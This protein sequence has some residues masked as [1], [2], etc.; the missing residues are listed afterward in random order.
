[1]YIGFGSVHL[2]NPEMFTE[3]VVKAAKNTDTRILI[4]K[5]WTGLGNGY[6]NQHIYTIGD[7]PH[8]TLFP[9]MAGIIHHGGSGTTHT[10]ARSGIPQFI[11]PQI[12]DQYYWGYS[13]YKQGIGPK[14]V[15]PK[16]ITVEKLS[17]AMEMLKNG[18][19]R[20][21]AQL[22]AQSMQH[23][24]GVAGIVNIVTK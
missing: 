3:M 8:G 10:A 17:E 4:G 7:V 23:E 21:N 19:Y 16:K 13:I 6:I 22:L 5:G 15:I 14:P 18:K 1:V 20:A 9:N 12:I 11:L 2:K 24:D